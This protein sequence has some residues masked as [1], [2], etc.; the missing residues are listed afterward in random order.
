MRAA[1]VQQTKFNIKESEK[2]SKKL[3]FLLLVYT[4][5]TVPVCIYS[6]Q[7]C[8]LNINNRLE[9]GLRFTV[10]LVYSFHRAK[11]WL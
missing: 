6:I 10:H 5:Y 3:T 4:D 7:F 8:K 2:A 9:A 11:F 1:R